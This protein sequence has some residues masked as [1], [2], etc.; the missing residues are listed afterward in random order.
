MVT[1][2][3]SINDI[4]G[5]DDRRPTPPAAMPSMRSPSPQIVKMRLLKSCDAP[6]SKRE[7]KAW[8]HRHPDT[9]PDA[10]AKA[11]WWFRR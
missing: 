2:L 10:L 3:L 9:I 11:R 8:P 1:R 5:P 4:A 7:A 6:S